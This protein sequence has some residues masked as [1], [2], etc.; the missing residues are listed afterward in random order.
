MASVLIGFHDLTGTD[1]VSGLYRHSKKTILTKISE[2]M[3]TFDKLT[4]TM[5]E[6][7]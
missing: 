2:R 3:K 4:S 1:A 7:L 6:N 5:E